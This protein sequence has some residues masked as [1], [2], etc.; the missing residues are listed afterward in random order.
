M[1]KI[2]INIGSSL[3]M[4]ILL[5]ACSASG[6]P[7]KS[8]QKEYVTQG[9]IGGG[10]LGAVAATAIGSG[11]NAGK[12]AIFGCGIGAVIGY[13]IA[14]RTDKYVDAGKAISTETQRNINTVNL[15][16]NNNNK[17]AARITKYKT[18]LNTIKYSKMSEQG[19]KRELTNISTSLKKQLNMSSSNLSSVQQE[20]KVT[21]SLYTKYKRSVP[22]DK[23][24]TYKN[25]I[26]ELEQEKNILSKHVQSLNAMNASI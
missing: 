15:V 2:Y 10:I 21:R 3:F 18:V 19:K 20:L 17:L 13:Q 1:N 12:A 22:K 26:S 16:R 14:K 24:S 9:C 8:K 4:G 25:K 6:G 11:E 7:G 23:S 5:T